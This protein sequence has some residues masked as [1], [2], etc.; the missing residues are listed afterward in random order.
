MPEIM[1]RQVI[2]AVLLPVLVLC[3]LGAYFGWG[4]GLIGIGVTVALTRP[5][6]PARTVKVRKITRVA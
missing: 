1:P 3:L 2:N 4:W 6:L 5:W